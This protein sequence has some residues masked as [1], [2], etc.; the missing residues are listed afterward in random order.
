MSKA[1]VARWK[2][3][4]KIG[5]DRASVKPDTRRLLFQS[6]AIYYRTTPDFILVLRILGI[7]QDPGRH[8]WDTGHPVA[9]AELSRRPPT[10]TLFHCSHAK[11]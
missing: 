8:L 3:F 7:R 2:T 9:C 6:H 10:I 11:L 5:S 4:A 1:Y